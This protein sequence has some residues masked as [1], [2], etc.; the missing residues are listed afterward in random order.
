MVS[1]KKI[2]AS[3]STSST[4]KS[5]FLNAFTVATTLFII[6]I[7]VNYNW[8]TET[9]RLFIYNRPVN[10]IGLDKCKVV[11]G[12]EGFEGCEDI[13]I[14]HK[15]GSA[16]LAC[17]NVKSRMTGWFP[18]LGMWNEV[19][20]VKDQPFVY[21]INAGTVKPLK[22]VNYPDD[23]ITLHGLGIYDDPNDPQNPTLFFVNHKR[24]GSVIEIFE[25]RI[26]TDELKHVETVKHELIHAPNDVA[27]ISKNEFYVTNDII[28]K[29]EFMRY[30]QIF[31]RLPY[32]DVVFHSGK[33]NTT[34]IVADGLRYANGIEM[35]RD[36][37]RVYVV[38]ST[39][40]AIVIY[41][42]KADNR[43]V[44]IERILTTEG[45]PDNISVDD[46]TNELYYTGV[47]RSDEVLPYVKSGGKT[48][49][50]SAAAV[51]ISDNV[52][53][54]RYYGKK[55]AQEI[56]LEDSETFYSLTV[57]AV[58]HSRNTLL[59][60]SIFMKGIGVCKLN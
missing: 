12:L 15:S 24:S 43:L 56:I 4:Q 41:E 59:L 32:S 14:H 6:L 21:D 46:V 47:V 1:T 27:P 57:A 18:P 22:L 39:E 35:N 11:K 49:K 36:Q 60:G 50:P 53:E 33:T 2:Q 42:R 29:N 54:D 10:Q 5:G 37:S 26:G 9:Y 45:F 58:D 25:H 23:D 34:T 28:Y 44:E 19:P 3:S 13:V 52:G 8:L 51:K 16:F 7:A 55:Y 38:C 20:I 17:G 31:L 40:P 30:A 48:Q